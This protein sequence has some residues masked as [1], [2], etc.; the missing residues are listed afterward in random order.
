M[1]IPLAFGALFLLAVGIVLGGLFFKLTEEPKSRVAETSDED[2]RPGK[3]ECTNH[4]FTDYSD[5]NSFKSE[6][7]KQYR[8]TDESYHDTNWHDR[9]V[10]FIKEAQTTDPESVEMRVVAEIYQKKIASCEHDGCN[11]KDEKYEQVDEYVVEEW[12]YAETPASGIRTRS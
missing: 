7:N 4:H 10:R 8:T 6:T 5:W 12:D 3:G 2:P 11:E 9:R 1:S